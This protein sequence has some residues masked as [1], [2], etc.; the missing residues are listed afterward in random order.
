MMYNSLANQMKIL[1]F[2][3]GDLNDVILK[4]QNASKTLFKWFN[5]NQMKANPDKCHFICSTSVKTSI[6]IENKQIRNSSC[7]KLLG[8]RFDSKLA[9]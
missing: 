2:V 9:F 1:L 4:F 5:D 7:E 3:S 8:V 6:M